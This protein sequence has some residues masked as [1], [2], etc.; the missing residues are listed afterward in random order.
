[1]FFFTIK[2]SKFL[3]KLY[4]ASLCFVFCINLTRKPQFHFEFNNLQVYL[5]TKFYHLQTIVFQT[6]HNVFVNL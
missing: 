5:F 1:M 2:Q 3:L 4:Y 6:Q